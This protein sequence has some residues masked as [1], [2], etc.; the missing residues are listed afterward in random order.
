MSK[1][2]TT[3]HFVSVFL[4]IFVEEYDKIFVTATFFLPAVNYTV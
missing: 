4:P 3:V 1:T 2:S